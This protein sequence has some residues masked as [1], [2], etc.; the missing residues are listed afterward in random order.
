MLLLSYLYHMGDTKYMV[1]WLPSMAIVYIARH[2]SHKLF[3]YLCIYS[4]DSM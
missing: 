1:G 3:T 4:H 2:D